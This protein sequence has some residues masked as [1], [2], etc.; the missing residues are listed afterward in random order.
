MYI[1]TLWFGYKMCHCQ[2][3]LSPIGNFLLGYMV[4]KCYRFESDE[5]YLVLEWCYESHMYTLYKTQYCSKPNRPIC[6]SS[7]ATTLD[8]NETQFHWIVDFDMCFIGN[9][10]NVCYG[11]GVIQ[12]GCL[13]ND[14]YNSKTT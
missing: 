5:G 9:I 14:H 7:W 2:P 4:W 1:E 11:Q 3:F 6:D 12:K 13:S 10:E 8:C